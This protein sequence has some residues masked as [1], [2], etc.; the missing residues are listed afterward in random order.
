MPAG[1]AVLSRHHVP[2]AF[3]H[4][5]DGYDRLVGLN[6]G[7]H[8]HLRSAARVVAGAVG[9]GAR[10]LDAGCGTG[11]STR[12]LLAVL[13]DPEVV[14]VDASAGMVAEA[15]RKTWPSTV[16]F[17]HAPVDSLPT[18]AV[19][20]P[21]DA[22]FAAYLLRN[23]PDPDATLLALRELL[24]PGGVLVVH[25]Y[26]LTGHVVPRLVWTAVCGSVIVPA[27]RMTAGDSQ[28][29]RYLWRSVREFDSPP[30][31]RNRLRAAGFTAVRHHSARGW[32]R[33]I[34]HTVAARRAR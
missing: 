1:A 12:A 10:V 27:A 20:G 13:P 16:R 28:L 21:F 23:V 29:Y 31:L 4:A 6:P 30:R 14:G 22:V 25:D 18:S 2:A 19:R 26:A 15:A 8:A 34:L 5:A 9:P 24:R 11:A 17:A 7:Y 3:D 32:Q 33:G